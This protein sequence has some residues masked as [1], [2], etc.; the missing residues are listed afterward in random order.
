MASQG[1]GVGRADGPAPDDIASMLFKDVHDGFLH[2]VQSKTG[3]RIR[4]STS[5]RLD[6]VGA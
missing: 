1:N 2:V 6:L 4:I 5:L 3:A